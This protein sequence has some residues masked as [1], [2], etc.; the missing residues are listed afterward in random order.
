MLTAP[1]EKCKVSTSPLNWS[2][3]NLEYLAIYCRPFYL[4]WEFS[5]VIITAVYIPSQVDTTI[6]PT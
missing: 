4:P 6:G 3:P 2:K 1:N 5:K